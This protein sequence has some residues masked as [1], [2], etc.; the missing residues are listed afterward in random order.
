[1]TIEPQN[2]SPTP[3]RGGSDRKAG[4]KPPKPGSTQPGSLGRVA[5]ESQGSGENDDDEVGEPGSQRGN[6]FQGGR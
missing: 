5:N 1:M 2:D 3:P 6:Q 4:P